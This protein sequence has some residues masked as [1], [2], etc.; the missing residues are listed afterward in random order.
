M[1]I[2]SSKPPTELTHDGVDRD[3]N[4]KK[5]MVTIYPKDLIGRTFLKDSKEDGQRFRVRVDRAV[6]D[7]EEEL[8][9]GSFQGSQLN[10]RQN[11]YLQ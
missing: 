6:V 4:V 7:R 8:K 1:F 10:S 2:H 9:K 5:R 3:P 11:L